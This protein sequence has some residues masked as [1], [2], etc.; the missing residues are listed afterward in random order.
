MTPGSAPS[1]GVSIPERGN[2]SSFNDRDSLC[3]GWQRSSTSA[4]RRWLLNLGVWRHALNHSMKSNLSR[5]WLVVLTLSL[6][7]IVFPPRRDTEQGRDR[8]G[9]P[10]RRFLWS[11]SLYEGSATAVGHHFAR[12]DL[13]KLSLEILS[14]AASG[15]ILSLALGCCRTEK[16]T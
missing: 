16:R 9:I 14:L 8:E 2:V 5:L 4:S 10:P 12:I 1:C 11:S 6:A 3:S 13:E 7:C 15:G